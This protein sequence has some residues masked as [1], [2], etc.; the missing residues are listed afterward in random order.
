[1]AITAAAPGC[2]TTSRVTNLPPESNSSTRTRNSLP[3]NG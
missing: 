1:M 2:S 3:M